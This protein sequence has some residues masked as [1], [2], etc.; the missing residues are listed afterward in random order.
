M[1]DLS[2]HTYGELVVLHDNIKRMLYIAIYTPSYSDSV[3]LQI[4]ERRMKIRA[5][6][7]TKELLQ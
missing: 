3:V 1:E 6:I 2:S 5:A 7:I 4:Q